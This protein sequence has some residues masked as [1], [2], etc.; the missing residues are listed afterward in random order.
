M[1][2]P[3]DLS[4]VWGYQIDMVLGR[5]VNQI[6]KGDTHTHPLLSCVQRQD[7]GLSASH[8]PRSV[9]REVPERVGRWKQ[10]L[11]QSASLTHRDQALDLPSEGQGHRPAN[12]ELA[13]VTTDPWTRTCSGLSFPS[14][15]GGHGPGWAVR[16]SQRGHLV[17][18]DWRQ[19]FGSEGRRKNGCSI[20]IHYFSFVFM[21]DLYLSYLK[22]KEW[23][24]LTKSTAT[25]K[26]GS[27]FLNSEAHFVSI[28]T[29]GEPA[30]RVSSRADLGSAW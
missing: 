2:R 16:G 8:L 22:K 14:W 15:K 30:P 1:Q 26:G 5:A 9:W 20:A 4:L 11:L 25:A 6:W 13:V 27:P 28:C 21:I 12:P 17:C 3:S 29:E 23:S 19:G 10:A 18:K 7:C 24:H